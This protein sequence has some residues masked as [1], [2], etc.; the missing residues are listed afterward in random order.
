MFE[1]GERILIR[2]T[3]L[4][5]CLL[6]LLLGG[7][8]ALGKMEW[9]EG[10]SRVEERYHLSR[11]T[12]SYETAIADDE[13]L[14]LAG[15]RGTQRNMYVIVKKEGEKLFTSQVFR[16][17]LEPRVLVD[18]QGLIHVLWVGQDEEQYSLFYTR[19]KGDGQ[20]EIEEEPLYSSPWQL[21]YPQ[22]EYHDEA[23]HLTWTALERPHYFMKY[24][25][26]QGDSFSQAVEIGD[27]QARV[28]RG[29]FTFDEF[30][31]MHVFYRMMDGFHMRLYYQAFDEDRQPLESVE[32]VAFLSYL[33]K[34]MQTPMDVELFLTARGEDLFLYYA[35]QSPETGPD[36]GSLF[37]L[38]RI[39]GSF[40]EAQ[41]LLPPMP[42]IRDP[43]FTQQGDAIFAVW[44]HRHGSLFRPFFLA[45]NLQGEVTKGPLDMDYSMADTFIPRVAAYE[46]GEVEMTWLRFGGQG[47]YYVQQRG[48]RYPEPPPLSFRL[49]FADTNPLIGYFYVMGV[50][51]TYGVVVALAQGLIVLVVFMI[52]SLCQRFGLLDNLERYPVHGALILFSGLFL[53]QDTLIHFLRPNTPGALFAVFVAVMTSV[54]AL[55]MKHGEREW[56]PLNSTM[57]WLFL[58]GLWVYWNTVF[59]LIP[60]LITT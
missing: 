19:L 30:G 40:Q 35:G 42:R 48:N 54:F 17:V 9:M 53:F 52:V 11:L 47:D 15:I 12:N 13:Y 3:T 20:V 44:T 57:G 4:L 36:L 43:Y 21:Q 41:I 39:E 7:G 18:P 5:L 29:V 45:M 16:R 51:L 46:D 50:S 1:K 32:E 26:I 55:I 27:R 24:M 22:M 33:D 2:H 38:T 37:L 31:S 34:D 49:G 8:E 59:S 28:L 56:L 60:H 25:E 10:W 58:M 6:F 14:L 23:L